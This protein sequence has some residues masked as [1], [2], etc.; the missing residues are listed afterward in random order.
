MVSLATRAH[1]TR[2]AHAGCLNHHWGFALLC[3]SEGDGPFHAVFA[4]VILKVTGK[5]AQPRFAFGFCHGKEVV[6]TKNDFLEMVRVDARASSLLRPLLISP[7][8][9]S[10]L[11]A[12]F[13]RDCLASRAFGICC[14][15]LDIGSQPACGKT[16]NICIQM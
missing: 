6:S 1:E 12:V 8:I 16:P 10:L 3:I 13:P 9:A 5:I 7:V 15:P 4:L 11:S 2:Q 14:E